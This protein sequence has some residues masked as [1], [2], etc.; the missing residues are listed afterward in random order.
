[1]NDDVNPRKMVILFNYCYYI[2]A[3]LLA[4]G[5]SCNVMKKHLLLRTDCWLE[6]NARCGGGFPA[7]TTIALSLSSSIFLLNSCCDN[8]E[9]EHP[10]V[11]IYAIS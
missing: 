9:Q 6:K 10:H 2:A 5:C 3:N 4:G 7:T 8:K 1:L 11:D